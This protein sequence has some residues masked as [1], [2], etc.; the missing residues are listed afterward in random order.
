[1]WRVALCVA[2]S[3][4]V[5]REKKIPF[6]RLRF[7]DEVGD[8]LSWGCFVNERTSTGDKYFSGGLHLLVAII[9]SPMAVYNYLTARK[10]G[11]ESWRKLRDD[12]YVIVRKAA[13]QFEDD[14]KREAVVNAIEKYLVGKA[15][16]IC[17]APPD[18]PGGFGQLVS[19][20]AGIAFPPKEIGM[21]PEEWMGKPIKDAIEQYGQTTRNE[22]I[23]DEIIGDLPDLGDLYI[24]GVT[25]KEPAKPKP[26]PSEKAEAAPAEGEGLEV[27]AEDGDEDPPF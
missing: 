4:E 13:V 10:A 12:L 11:D 5:S 26:A 23:G 21:E 19:P 14:K 3:V 8:V 24:P 16:N 20:D 15:F 6:I 1:M 7:V 9:K 25:D 22:A 17:F 27:F 18:E 2:A